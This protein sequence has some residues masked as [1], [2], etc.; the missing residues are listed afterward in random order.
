VDADDARR[1]FEDAKR[2][3]ERAR[4]DMEKD[5][6]DAERRVVDVRGPR[7][8]PAPAAVPAMSEKPVAPMAPKPA[9]PTITGGKLVTGTLNG[10]GPEIS[11]S[12]MNGEVIVRKADV[13]R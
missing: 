2:D 11:V 3:L 1:Q 13:K 8:I 5:K 7:A 4:R 12:T 6:R 9:I 10:G